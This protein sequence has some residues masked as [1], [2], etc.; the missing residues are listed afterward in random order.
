MQF[1]DTTEQSMNSKLKIIYFAGKLSRTGNQ[2]TERLNELP[3]IKKEISEQ[4]RTEPSPS[5][6]SAPRPQSSA[7]CL[8]DGCWVA[9]GRTWLH[10]ELQQ[11]ARYLWPRCSSR[12]MF[13]VKCLRA[14]FLSSTIHKH[15]VVLVQ[16]WPENKNSVLQYFL[17][18]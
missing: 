5:P 9:L 18:F 1:V 17:R 14:T 12:I 13:F 11:A 10:G 15:A 16:N 3:E 6:S 4:A 8:C 2:S 7:Q